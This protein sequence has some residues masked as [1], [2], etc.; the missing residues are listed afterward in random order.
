MY[1]T[2]RDSLRGTEL[3]PSQTRT[4]VVFAVTKVCKEKEEKNLSG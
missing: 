1:L 4:L 3:R 2:M